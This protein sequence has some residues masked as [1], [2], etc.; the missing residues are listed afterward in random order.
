MKDKFA[1]YAAGLNAPP[2]EAAAI[3][4]DDRAELPWPT[5]ALYVGTTGSVRAIMLSGETADF[6]DLQGGLMYP[7][8]VR[9]VL[10]EGTTAAD[11]V[12]LR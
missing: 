7:L 6:K 2:S 1:T 3:T 8:R 9:R 10:A 4:P 11:L 5:R 12:A